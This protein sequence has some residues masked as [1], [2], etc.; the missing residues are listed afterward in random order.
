MTAKKKA[1]KKDKG[2]PVS[3]LDEIHEIKEGLNAAHQVATN[4]PHDLSNAITKA[5]HGLTD[6]VNRHKGEPKE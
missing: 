3:I 1:T 4:V 6:L 2:L 5:F